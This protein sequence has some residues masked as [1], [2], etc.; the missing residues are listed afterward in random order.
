MEGVRQ[1]LLGEQRRTIVV[2]ISPE[3]S[4]ITSSETCYKKNKPHESIRFG[5]H[6]G[7]HIEEHIVCALTVRFVY[8]RPDCLA[9]ASRHLTF[10]LYNGNLR[11]RRTFWGEETFSGESFLGEEA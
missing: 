7:Q 1:E 8:A 3:S 11:W 10:Q 9:T 4:P 6:T 2:L 5:P